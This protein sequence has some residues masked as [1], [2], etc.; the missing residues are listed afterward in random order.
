VASSMSEARK[1]QL[2]YYA[3]YIL[4]WIFMIMTMNAMRVKNYVGA[5][6]GFFMVSLIFMWTRKW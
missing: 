4:F 5:S 2:E 1:S 3:I 6:V